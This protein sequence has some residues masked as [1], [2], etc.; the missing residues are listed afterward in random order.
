[1]R[2]RALGADRGV[3]CERPNARGRH[4][5]ARVRHR[6]DVR[7]AHR[8]RGAGRD[9]R[10]AAT[11]RRA[12]DP[13]QRLDHRDHRGPRRPDR[14]VPRGLPALRH[15]ARGRRPD[16]TRYFEASPLLSSSFNFEPW[17]VLPGLKFLRICS[18]SSSDVGPGIWNWGCPAIPV[19]SASL[20]A[21]TPSL[22]ATGIVSWLFRWSRA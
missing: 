10:G 1:D 8:A 9:W 3:A 7:W 15:V 2:N 20:G 19:T 16:L 6:L 22:E 13:G 18:T 21:C 17:I 5:D 12:G 11:W 14:S 4:D